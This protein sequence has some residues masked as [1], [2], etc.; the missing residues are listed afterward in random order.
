MARPRCQNGTPRVSHDE[1]LLCRGVATVYNE[2]FFWI[3]I[4]KHLV[5]VHRLF[6]DPNKGLMRVQIRMK[7]SEKCTVPRR[8]DEIHKCDN[9]LPTK[10][11]VFMFD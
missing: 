7:L 4:F 5:V 9:C 11:G 6:R 8:L 3:F 10:S 2:Q 1:A